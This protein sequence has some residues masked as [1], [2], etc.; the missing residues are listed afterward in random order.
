MTDAR[1][2]ISTPVRPRVRTF[3]SIPRVEASASNSNVRSTPSITS[4]WASGMI[5]AVRLAAMTPAR[6]AVASTL[7]LA[8]RPARRFARVSGP[9]E[10]SPR[11]T[12]TRAVTFFPLTSTMRTR[13]ERS[14]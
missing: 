5:S 7:P 9:M 1:A 12:A 2:S 3:D 4:G 14:T 6:Y 8:V 13:P 11:A 10:T